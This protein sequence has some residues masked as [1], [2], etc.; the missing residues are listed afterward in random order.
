MS[1]GKPVD[2]VG[3]VSDVTSEV[4]TLDGILECVIQLDAF[5]SI[6]ASVSMEFAILHVVKLGNNSLV[7]CFQ[8][9]FLLRLPKRGEA[10]VF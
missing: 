9:D 2:M 10:R 7:M 1:L 5:I 4:A 6:M 3:R 8:K